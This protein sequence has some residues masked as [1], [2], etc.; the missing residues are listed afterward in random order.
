MLSS[1]AI[2]SV[3]IHAVFDILYETLIDPPLKNIKSL[4]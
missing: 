1:S 2:V 4:L 3:R